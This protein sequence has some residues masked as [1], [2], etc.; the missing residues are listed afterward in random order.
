MS[1]RG[2]ETSKWSRRYPLARPA[3]LPK[4]GER[5]QPRH[6]QPLPR[7]LFERISEL[8]GIPL[9][10]L[11]PIR[12]GLN[13]HPKPLK[14]KQL[15]KYVPSIH[16]IKMPS[17][18]DPTQ[19]RRTYHRIRHAAIMGPRTSLG[20]HEQIHSVH[21]LFDASPGSVISEAISSAGEYPR[22]V[23]A[24]EKEA[25]S[26]VN[27]FY[28]K[29]GADGLLVLM[30]INRRVE[31]LDDAERIEKQLLAQGVLA[32]GGLTKLGKVFFEGIRQRIEV[33][34]AE[35]ERRRANG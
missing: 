1:S 31:K 34:L 21:G 35:V 23:Q 2:S 12:I 19:L 24:F 5:F 8:T 33:R 22:T 32:K 18:F 3:F 27:R 4:V 28:Y 20:Q 17:V 29:Y 14:T 25:F 15:G 26:L 30:A 10:K 7:R 16:A 6:L 13:E 9:Q 11:L